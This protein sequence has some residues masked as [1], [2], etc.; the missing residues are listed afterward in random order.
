M[1]EDPG[2]DLASSVLFLNSSGQNSDG[3]AVAS[4]GNFNNAMG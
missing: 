1:S 2:S 4:P 3:D